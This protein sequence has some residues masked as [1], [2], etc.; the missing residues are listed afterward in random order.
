MPCSESLGGLVPERG[1]ES[2]AA[3]SAVLPGLTVPLSKFSLTPDSDRESRKPEGFNKMPVP[4]SRIGCVVR[5][6]VSSCLLSALTLCPYVRVWPWP[7]NRWGKLK[8]FCSCHGNYEAPLHQVPQLLGAPRWDGLFSPSNDQ[9]C[10]PG[11]VTNSSIYPPIHHSLTS[12][13]NLCQ[14]IMLH[15][16]KYAH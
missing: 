14:L 7:L 3:S 9:L 4:E 6:W 12:K 16:K 11:K 1:L 15:E 8:G 13:N 2:G 5:A 10:Y